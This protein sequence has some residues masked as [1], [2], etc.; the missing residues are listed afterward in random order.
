VVVRGE[1]Q[2]NRVHHVTFNKENCRDYRPNRRPGEHEVGRSATKEIV[3]H[4]K[5]RKDGDSGK[6]GWKGERESLMV[7][8]SNEEGE[9]IV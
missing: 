6:S 1:P 5:K 9:P 8:Y 7:G 4:E 3:S 2:K